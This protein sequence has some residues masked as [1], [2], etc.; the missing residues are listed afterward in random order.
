MGPRYSGHHG[1]R[2]DCRDTAVNQVKVWIKGG[3]VSSDLWRKWIPALV[4]TP[5][6][7]QQIADLALMGMLG[8]AEP[9]AIVPLAEFRFK[10]LFALNKPG[11]NGPDE[12]LAAAKS[13]YNVCDIKYTA[14]AVTL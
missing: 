10:A 3:W 5:T 6:T 1:S 14:N 8:R 7:N 11:P 12:L 9:A 2:R 13:Y 4:N